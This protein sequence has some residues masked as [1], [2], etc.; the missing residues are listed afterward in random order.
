MEKRRTTKKKLQ[1]NKRQKEEQKEEKK[2]G[3]TQAFTIFFNCESRFTGTKNKLE[4]GKKR[5]RPIAISR[6]RNRRR[7]HRRTEKDGQS[8]FLSRVQAIKK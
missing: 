3:K 4:S 7:T 8:A 5:I 1:K 6:V 2:R